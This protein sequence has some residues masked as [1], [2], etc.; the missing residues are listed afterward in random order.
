MIVTRTITSTSPTLSLTAGVACAHR[1]CVLVIQGT[2]VQVIATVGL[3]GD[4]RR[5]VLNDHLQ[6]SITGGHPSLHDGLR[7]EQYNATHQDST[8]H[9]HEIYHAARN[10]LLYSPRRLVVKLAKF[11]SGAHSVQKIRI[12]SNGVY[13]RSF[14]TRLRAHILFANS[15][16]MIS[17]KNRILFLNPHKSR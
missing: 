6:H 8:R 13:F 1:F 9:P 16:N 3:G 7:L 11:G 12:P 10:M 14:P 2:G 15:K 17:A 5:Q 4:R